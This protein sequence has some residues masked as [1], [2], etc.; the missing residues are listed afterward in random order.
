VGTPD[1]QQGAATLLLVAVVGLCM[2]LTAAGL[3]ISRV[4]IARVRVS[5]AAD[6]AALAAAESMDCAHAR[7]VVEANRA[8]L[9]DCEVQGTDVQ[10][11]V[12]LELR[13][14]GRRLEFTAAAR[15]GPP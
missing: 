8:R 2:V 5:S 12:G 13:V 9:L 10:V 14:A 7:D 1:G 4:A 11:S 3:G 6:L 15:A